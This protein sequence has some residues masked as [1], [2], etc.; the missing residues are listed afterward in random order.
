MGALHRRG[1]L[2][3][4][5]DHREAAICTQVIVNKC[6]TSGFY[7]L[8]LSFYI[9]QFLK[10]TFYCNDY[11]ITACGISNTSNT[12]TVDIDCCIN[13]SWNVFGQTVE[14][15]SS[16]TPMVPH[17]CVL[18]NTGRGLG[19][20]TCEADDMFPP[21]DLWFDSDINLNCACVYY[22]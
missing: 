14:T 2:R 8:W 1:P 10:I 11:R 19:T 20:E 7:A 4:V 6:P 9:C 13:W 21:D 15:E 3:L 18:L 16:S 22:L 17:M 5:I 12:S